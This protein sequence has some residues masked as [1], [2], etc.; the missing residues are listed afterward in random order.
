MKKLKSTVYLLIIIAVSCAE[1]TAN[2]DAVHD[3]TTDTIT[4]VQVSAQQTIP[5]Q[6]SRDT[7]QIQLLIE[8]YLAKHKKNKRIR[9]V[10]EW[11]L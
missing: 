1:P 4:K 2:K 5:E 3:L 10:D 6:R 7:I 9:Y 8:K 11:N